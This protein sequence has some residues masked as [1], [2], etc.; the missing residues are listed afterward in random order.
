VLWLMLDHPAAAERLRGYANAQGIDPRRVIFA[1]RIPLPQH[2]ARY[3]ASDLA[4]DTYPYTSHTTA[5]DALWGDC[6]LVG[7]SGNT[8][9]SRVSGSILTSAGLSH[10]V[11]RN[12]ADYYSLARD[13]ATT[14][15]RLSEVRAQVKRAKSDSALFD[16]ERF[17]RDLE[18]LYE[19]IITR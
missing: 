14:P 18:T 6:P 16:T 10:L 5:S 12:L 13:L 1:P 7:L 9:A 3:G 17:T 11:T 2:L 15:H 19:R 8:F 4:L